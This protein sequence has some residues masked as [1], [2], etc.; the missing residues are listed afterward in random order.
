MAPNVEAIQ[1]FKINTNSYD[2]AIGRTGG[3]AVNTSVTGNDFG[4]VDI[5]SGTLNVTC[6]DSSRKS[7]L[8]RPNESTRS[9]IRRRPPARVLCFNGGR[10][11][12][13]AR[14]NSAA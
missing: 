13:P 10:I 12:E 14:T 7:R 9:R 11:R 2:A 6:P 3:G 8:E 5:G 1:E 4:A